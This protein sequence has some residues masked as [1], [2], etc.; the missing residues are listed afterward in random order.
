L[1]LVLPFATWQRAD[2]VGLKYLE[3]E[4]LYGKPSCKKMDEDT[5]F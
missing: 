2:L 3:M 1:L 5:W 4:K